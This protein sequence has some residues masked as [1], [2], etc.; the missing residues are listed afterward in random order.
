M[1][2]GLL[3]ATMGRVVHDAVGVMLGLVGG[4]LVGEIASGLT[5]GFLWYWGLVFRWTEWPARE[6]LSLLALSGVYG[7]LIGGALAGLIGS[8]RVV[9]R[10][11]R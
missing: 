11:P 7:A 1:I 3:G 2:G 6:D 10:F 5:S 4:G 8:L 9:P